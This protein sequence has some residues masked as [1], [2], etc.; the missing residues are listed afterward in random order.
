MAGEVR[1]FTRPH[2]AADALVGARLRAARQAAGLTLAAVADRAGLTKGFLSRLERDEVSPSVA[3]LVAVCSVLGIG[4]GQLFE[5]PATSLVRAGEAPPTNFGG[6]G[7]REVLL[8]AGTQRALHVIRSVVEPGGGGGD[9][10]YALACDVE[11]VHV[12]RGRLRLLLPGEVVDLHEG[13]AFTMPGTTP[14]TWLN[15]STAP[16]EVLWVLTPAP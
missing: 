2:D 6:A 10:L 11:F 12:L 8:T 16:C 5:P 14:H 3:S 13:D 9:E 4:V 15:P 7:V 1:R